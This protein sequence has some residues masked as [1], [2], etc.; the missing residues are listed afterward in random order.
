MSLLQNSERDLESLIQWAMNDLIAEKLQRLKVGHADLINQREGREDPSRDL[1]GEDQWIQI[2]W[3][4][5]P[6][7]IKAE[8]R[9]QRI[10]SRVCCLNRRGSPVSLLEVAVAG[11][12]RRQ[13]RKKKQKPRF[14]V[15]VTKE[16]VRPRQESNIHI[17]TL[18]R[19]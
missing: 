17:L 8:D 11:G 16:R 10:L 4:L 7:K 14:F 15:T 3:W 19:F 1:F 5:L 2:C 12:E 6:G 18:L 13:R 9:N